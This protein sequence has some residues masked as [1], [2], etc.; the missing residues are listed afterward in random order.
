MHHSHQPD[1]HYKTN[2]V[3]DTSCDYIDFVQH[4]DQPYYQATINSTHDD[5]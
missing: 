4:N 3:E 1:H 5:H 2:G